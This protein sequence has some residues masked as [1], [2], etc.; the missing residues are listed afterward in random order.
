[1]FWLCELDRDLR[2]LAAAKER[3]DPRDT[4]ARNYCIEY[5]RGRISYIIEQIRRGEQ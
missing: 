1:M 5:D 3:R 2:G 4:W